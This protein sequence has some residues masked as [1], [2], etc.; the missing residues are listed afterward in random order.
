MRC[1]YLGFIYGK[2]RR[3]VKSFS[4]RMR[5]NVLG[6]VDFASK[7]VVTVTNDTY[8]AATEVCEI[9]RKISAK[10]TDRDTGRAST[11]LLTT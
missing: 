7:E 1:D 4:R 9:L 10:Y 11:W 5:Y 2:V 3:F 6:V 8:I